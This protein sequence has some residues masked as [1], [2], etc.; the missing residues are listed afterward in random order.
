MTCLGFSTAVCLLCQTAGVSAEKMF[1]RSAFIIYVQYLLK[2][3]PS[4]GA[5]LEA[6]SIFLAKAKCVLP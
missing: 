5:W 2:R 1:A 6:E 4:S 3:S